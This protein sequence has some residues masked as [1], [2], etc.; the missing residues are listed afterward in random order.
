MS[1]YMRQNSYY[2]QYYIQQIYKIILNACLEQ[3]EYTFFVYRYVMLN[4]KL[5]LEH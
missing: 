4:V 5:A 1:K 2:L 3:E